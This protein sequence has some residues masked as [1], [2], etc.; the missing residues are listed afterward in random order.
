MNHTQPAA[1]IKVKT[2]F[3][4]F[5]LRQYDKGNIL[6]HAGDEPQGVFYLHKG[7]V[8]QYAIND[9]GDEIVVNVFKPGAFFLM[10][11]A[12]NKT[13]NRYFLDALE[14]VEVYVAPAERVVQFVQTNPDVLF[15]LLQ[16]VYSGVDGI[17][18]RMVLLMGGDAR[19][20]L[21]LEL[22]ISA[23]RTGVPRGSNSHTVHL[24]ESDLATRTGMSRETVSREMRHLKK[25]GLVEVAYKQ[26]TLLDV[27]ALEKAVRPEV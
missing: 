3:A 4:D 13:P 5:P 2:F 10:S 17:L 22:L 23:R 1:A 20:R 15:D 11:W 12:I 21:M 18:E 14:D 7:Q 6:V 16:R 25:T 27:R 26:I 19:S 9:R 8:R 24:T